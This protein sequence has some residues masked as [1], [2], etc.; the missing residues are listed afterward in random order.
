MKILVSAVSFS[1]KIS[2]IQRHAFNLVRCLL[3]RQD[4]STVDL[5]LAPWQQQMLETVGV[6]R[7]TRLRIHIAGLH[8]NS[9]SRNLWHYSTLPLLAHELRPDL[10]HFTYPVPINADALQC[11]TV[12]T[13][14][15]LYPY[16]IPANFRF[17]HVFI[18]RLILQH[19]LQSV[20]V[21]ACVSE[22]TLLRL[23]QH[24]P[25]DV[26]RRAVR[27]YNCVQPPMGLKMTAL[28]EVQGQPF[29]L[30]VA[31]HRRNKNISLLISAFRSMR[32]RGL[33][34]MGTKLL[35][36]GIPGPE[37]PRLRALVEQLRLERNVIFV[38]GLSDSTLQWC[39]QHCESLVAPSI[40]EGFGLPIAEALLAGCRVVCSDI[41]ALREV[42][43]EHCRYFSL[44]FNEEENLASAIAAA[45]RLPRPRPA[46]LPFL[47]REQIAEQYMHLYRRVTEEHL[48]RTASEERSEL[49][50]GSALRGV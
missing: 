7:E 20:D 41:P 3:A 30:C 35:I 1:S 32:Q 21:I 48:A 33:L 31:Q 18:N 16:E 28:T 42:G 34:P 13:L 50:D 46:L 29:L 38:D 10:I 27:I 36:V 40:T 5:V 14:H 49:R 37:T 8:A 6:G 12:L 47:S 44:G 24:V 39:Y 26:A 45:L 43:R 15:D 23:R 2:G 4:I 9:F 11:P 22:A 17:P 25:E 19:S